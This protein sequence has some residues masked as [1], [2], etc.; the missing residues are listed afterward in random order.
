LIEFIVAMPAD[1]PNIAAR[2]ASRSFRVGSDTVHP[3]FPRLHLGKDRVSYLPQ[4]RDTGNGH[5]ALAGLHPQIGALTAA[6]D[7]NFRRV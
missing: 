7:E 2:A 1:A 5:V 4:C 3:S 6:N